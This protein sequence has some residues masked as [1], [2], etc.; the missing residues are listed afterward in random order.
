MRKREQV[1]E[2][3][4]IQRQGEREGGRE[5]REREEGDRRQDRSLSVVTVK[6]ERGR[7]GEKRERRGGQKTG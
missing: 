3:T 6:S 7:E 1:G 2:G 5:R 4:E